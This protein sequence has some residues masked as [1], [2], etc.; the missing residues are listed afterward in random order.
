MLGTVLALLN[1][2]LSGE[3][4]ALKN[5]FFQALDT[6]EWGIIFAVFFKVLNAFFQPYIEAQIEKLKKLLEKSYE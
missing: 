2:D 6:T 4:S 5:N 3:T 1:L